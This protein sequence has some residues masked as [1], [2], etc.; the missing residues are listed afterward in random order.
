[1]GLLAVLE[2]L[3]HRRLVGDGGVHLLGVGLYESER[4]DGAAAGAQDHGRAGVEVA[5]EPGEVVGAQLRG[6]SPGRGRRPG[7]G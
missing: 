3:L 6:S 5:Q 1:V 4:G 7:Y 2:Q